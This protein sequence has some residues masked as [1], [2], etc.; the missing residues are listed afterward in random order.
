MTGSR[1]YI[2]IDEGYGRDKRENGCRMECEDVEGKRPNAE[3]G[4]L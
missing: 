4:S 3:V 1:R 2:S